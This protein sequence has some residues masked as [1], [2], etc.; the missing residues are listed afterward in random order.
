M[1]IVPETKE[2]PAVQEGIRLQGLGWFL[3]PLHGIDESGNCTCGRIPCP[4]SPGKHPVPADGWKSASTRTADLWT[5]FHRRPDANLGVSLEQSGL[6]VIGPDSPEWLKE[7]ELLGLAAT[8]TVRSGG[9]DGHL[10]FYYRR[11]DGCPLS[12]SNKSAEYDIQSS[13]YMVAPPSR[14]ISGNCYSWIKHPLEFRELPPAPAWAVNM[15]QAVP[16]LRQVN[17]ELQLPLVPELD[18]DQPPVE[19]DP[20]GTLLWSGQEYVG[21]ERHVDRSETLYAIGAALA[22]A[23]ADHAQL[24]A[25]LANR[26]RALGLLK[27]TRRPVEYQR[28]AVK[29]LG[30]VA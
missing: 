10:H 7:F 27:Y 16:E 23:G 20:D 1:I 24:V 22:D 11:P 17:L 8:A 18:G 4:H 30:P 15:L 5:W 28:I 2:L 9:G 13:G 3:L 14:H 26:D 21:T 25:C 6:L 29:L 12:R 19:L